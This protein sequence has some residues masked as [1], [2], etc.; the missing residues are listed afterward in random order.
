MLVAATCIAGASPHAAA[1]SGPAYAEL[2]LRWKRFTTDRDGLQANSTRAIYVG[3][4]ELWIGGQGGFSHFNGRWTAYAHVTGLA[5]DQEIGE[6]RAFVKDARPARLWAGTDSGLLLAW[7]G[8]EWF[9]VADLRSPI[10]AL[11]MVEGELWAGTDDG[12]VRFNGVDALLLDALGR[13]PVYAIEPVADKVW[14][15]AD[16]GLW[17][18]HDKHW[19]RVGGSEPNLAYGVYALTVD[20]AGALYAGTPFGVGRLPSR[21]A[22][23]EW[24]STLDDAGNPALV[25]TL[26]VDQRGV[27]WAGTDG[28]GAY[29]FD[30]AQG[31]VTAYG[32]IGDM[33]LATRFIRRIGV[34]RDNSIWFTT[35]GGVFRFQAYRWI[36]DVQGEPDDVQ[37]HVNDMLVARDGALW[38]VTAGAGVRRKSEPGGSDV[39]FTAAD[40]A[41]DAG[42]AIAQDVRGAVWVGADEGVR[43]Y[44]D[45]LW[46]VPLDPEELPSPVV[47]SFLVDGSQ[48]WIGTT[49]GLLVTDAVSAARRRETALDGISVEALALD[50]QGDLWVGTYGAG[51][52]ERE[53]D[54]R[55]RQFRH[56]PADR[57][58]LPGD[59]VVAHGLAPDPSYPDGMWV[60]VEGG[61]LARWTG[62]RWQMGNELFPVPSGLLWTLYTDPDDGSLWIGSETGVTRYDGRTWTT[63]GVEDGLQSPVIFAVVRSMEG[64]YW[65]GGSTGLTYFL[66]DETPPWV[67]FADFG[68]EVLLGPND[69]PLLTVGESLMVR[70]HAGDLQTAE[71]KLTVLQRVTGPNL[72]TPWTATDGDYLREKFDKPGVYTLE[73]QARDLS[74]NYSA[75]ASQVIRVIVP[76]RLVPLPVLG[77][78]EVGVFRTL[79][80][81]GGLVVFGMVYMTVVVLNNR[82]RS[83]EALAR[84]FNPYISG[85]PVRRDDMFFGRRELLQRIIDSLHSNS[86]MIH[87]ERRIGKTSLLLQLVTTLREVDDPEYW[88]VP[89][90]IDMEGTPQEDFFTLLIEEILATAETLADAEVTI[91]PKLHQ[92]RYYTKATGVYNDR[93]F[94]R[95]LY[96]VTEA[97]EAYGEIHDPGKHLRVILL[98]D[99]MDVMSSYDRLIQQQ[100]RRIFMREFAATLGAVVA[101]IQ[102]S[103]DWDRV[104]SPWFNL[105]NEIELT[106]FT[107]EQA[108]ELLTEPVRGYYVYEPA[109]LE[110]VL[111]NA[112]G[113]P[114]RLQQYGLEAVNHMLVRKRRRITLEDVEAAHH[115][116]QV[117]ERSHMGKEGT[118]QPL[119]RAQQMLGAWQVN[120]QRGRAKSSG[121]LATS[122]DGPEGPAADAE[123]RAG[124]P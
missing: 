83:L 68:R 46:D 109:A 7:E 122:T 69:L 65:F 60:I 92:L 22:R 97:L 101:G 42:Y 5:A 119:A 31:S 116:I 13:R 66:P 10:H 123:S 12:A 17:L 79:L 85:E 87:G 96:K 21:D 124:Q 100:L 74:F 70:Y 45:G 50:N 120:L 32:Y 62:Q 52:W 106:P 112:A 34:D 57:M 72:A 94:Y 90:Y 23:W 59:R 117:A 118:H 53:D 38:V 115:R 27:I 67:T 29:A 98:M 99:E 113:R 36:N 51:V 4:T 30:F 61:G 3:D 39:S 63:F 114:Y 89:V 73:L 76:P 56:N 18:Y 24:L 8:V 16:D 48:I 20:A 44:M 80:V 55:W 15:G 88:F 78:V 105:F 82:R 25:Q 86:I 81:L 41:V 93:D 1:V 40:G 71:D 11:A 84:G 104:E 121:K 2:D 37:N 77:E 33:D 43:R 95:D 110:F 64:G 91:A 108:I 6:V 28:A 14:V 26:A 35:P 58:S 75:I 107:R 47:T 19:S 9:F 54:G 102:I 49:G 111:A 103:K